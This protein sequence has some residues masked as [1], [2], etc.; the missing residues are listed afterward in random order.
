MQDI[1]SFK[2][3]G[4]PQLPC[5]TFSTVPIFSLFLSLKKWAVQ[6]CSIHE[7][8][9]HALKLGPVELC[10]FAAVAFSASSRVYANA[11]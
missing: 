4:S 3:K 7:E 8:G 9:L 2:I 10:D 6:G 5:G 11:T 1:F